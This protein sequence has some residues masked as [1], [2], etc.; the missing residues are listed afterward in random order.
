M[1][2]TKLS[3]KLQKIAKELEGLTVVEMAELS[4]YLEDKFGVMPIATSA[5]PAQTASAT[6]SADKEEKTSFTVMLA[7]SGE[8]KLGVIKAVRE[9]LPNLGLMEAKKLVESAPKE[10]LKDVKKDIAEEAKKKVE[11]AGGKVELK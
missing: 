6:A 1:A 10:L 11:T 7:S 8:N 5:A 2:E 4:K 9:I 3:E